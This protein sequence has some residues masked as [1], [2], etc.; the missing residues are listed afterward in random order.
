M[1]QARKPT[2]LG[3]ELRTWG[4]KR[5]GAGRKAGKR[6]KVP[7]RARP[8]HKERHPVHVTLRAASGLPSFRQ[9]LV[10]SLL[11]R[12][13]QQQ[14]R[15]DYEPDFQVVHFSIQHNHLHLIVEADE[16]ALRAGVS[17]L[18]IA[19]A[20]RL[21][22][23]LRRRGSVWGDRYHRHDLATPREVHHTLSYVFNNAKKHGLRVLGQGFV[24]PYSSAR[25]FHGW[26]SEVFEYGEPDPWPKVRART[27]LLG[28]G[29]KKRGFIDPNATPSGRRSSR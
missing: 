5:A 11:C 26:A 6:P 2:Q 20:R 17:G 29:W 14:Q 13:L 19:F 10:D 16:R 28:Q 3:L 21:N 24:D 8:P 25:R 9:E 7:H 18:M 22:A 4:G 23:L 1:R 15:K 27:W 12:V